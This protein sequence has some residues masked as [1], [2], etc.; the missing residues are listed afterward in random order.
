MSASSKAILRISVELNFATIFANTTVTKTPAAQILGLKFLLA[1]CWRVRVAGQALSVTSK[2]AAG[3]VGS[4][5]FSS[6][7]RCAAQ[8]FCGL[9]GSEKEQLL[10]SFQAHPRSPLIFR[11]GNDANMAA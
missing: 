1:L 4:I 5:S 6:D 8:K 3:E 2:A 7:W 11:P 10:E 9:P